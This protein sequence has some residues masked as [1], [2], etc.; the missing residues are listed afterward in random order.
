MEFYGVLLS[1]S[2]LL[3]II[4]AILHFKHKTK[5]PPGPKGLPIIGSLLAV[6]DRPHD[7]LTKLAKV[8]GP[9]MTVRMGP[10]S[11]IVVSSTEMAREIILRNDQAFLGRPVPDAVTAQAD[12]ELSMPWLSGDAQWK[13]LRK[14]CTS[15]IFT[16][17][18]LDSLQ[19]LRHQMMDNMVQRI[20]E[21]K[22]TPVSIGKLVFATTFS[23]ISNTM[24]STDVL[25]P[26]STSVEE[27]KGLMGRIMELGAKPN[28]AD[29]FPLLKPFDLQGIRKE[30]KVSYDRLHELLEGIIDRRLKRRE[31]ALPRSDDLLDVLLDRN[32]EH[33]AD[34]L[35]RPDIKILLVVSSALSLSH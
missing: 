26:N 16:T 27:M 23:L 21:A 3:I 19:W 18:G 11:T 1:S 9:I 28:M 33:G 7:S 2:L 12:Y 6:G 25:D 5:L 29:Y 34:E 10:I 14:L 20:K 13:K 32:E 35:S 31:L 22:G 30:I 17:Q 24:F 8:Y 4:H 15:Q